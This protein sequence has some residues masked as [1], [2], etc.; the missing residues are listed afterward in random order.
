[1]LALIFD[2]ETSGKAAFKEP[3]VSPLQPNLVQLGCLLVDL[4]SGKEH[5]AVDLIVFPSSWDIPQEAAL[6][7][8][9]STGLAKRTGVNLDT[10]VNI[11]LDLVDVCDVVVAHNIAFDRI[12]MERATAMVNLANGDEVI[13]PFDGKALFCTMRAATPIVKKKSRRPLHDQDYKWPK[14]AECVEFFF[15]E[16]LE[17]AHS[18][19]VDC[20][21]CARILIE[22]ASKGLI[23]LPTEAG[24]HQ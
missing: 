19:I 1:M 20:R 22:M 2:T 14:L 6:I 24:F 15:Q 18:A 3:S 13:D 7:H 4:E 23:E 16:E 5:A 12:I 10:A 9:V 11:F 8:G 21:A 17:N